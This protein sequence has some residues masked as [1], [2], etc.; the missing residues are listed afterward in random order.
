MVSDSDQT[1]AI[2]MKQ[3]FGNRHNRRRQGGYKQG[4][5]YMPAFNLTDDILKPYL[6]ASALWKKERTLE[7]E[8]WIAEKLMVFFDGMLVSDAP[9]QGAITGETVARY[10]AQRKADGVA[11]GSIK[12][13]LAVASSAVNWAIG[14]LNYDCRNPFAGRLITQADKRAIKARK[15]ILEQA[16]VKALMLAATGLVQDIIMFAATT[17]CR[18]SEILNLTWDQIHGDELHFTPEQ[19]KGGR[20]SVRALNDAALNILSRQSKR[21]EYVFTDD[22]GLKLK[23][24]NFHHRWERVRKRAG[25]E[26]VKFHDLRRYC[27]TRLLTVGSMENV[28]TQ[29]GHADIRTTQ[30]AYAEDDVK[31]VK[32]ALRKLA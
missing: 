3:S 26:D 20:H 23:R 32:E 8:R 5:N 10:R 22:C 30:S 13:E 29:L 16:E 18:Q 28:K 15:R 7:T 4:T 19:N 9:A 21:G 11:A 12:R 27:A 17:G 1:G 2:N 6:S 31:G 14:E 24:R 25:V